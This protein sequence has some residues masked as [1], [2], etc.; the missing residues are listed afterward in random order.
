MYLPLWIIIGKSMLP[1]PKWIVGEVSG[2]GAWGGT[3]RGGYVLAVVVGC[4][5]GL[6]WNISEA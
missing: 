3:S 6:H 2:G 1:P 4:C 5:V